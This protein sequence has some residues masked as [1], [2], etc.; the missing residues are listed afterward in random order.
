[1]FD[2]RKGLEQT[3]T[4]LMELRIQVRRDYVDQDKKLS[5]DI[6][7]TLARIRELDSRDGI[8]TDERS[9]RE[10]AATSIPDTPTDQQSNYKKNRRSYDFEEIA[11]KV[12]TILTENSGEM[13][14][15][16]ICRVLEIRHGI[17]FSNRT[18]AFRS[19]IHYSTKIKKE[20][21]KYK[22]V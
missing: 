3:L 14:A 19:M 7:E 21:H 11:K 4:H 8:A 15:A 20:G 6:K 17:S 10:I 18:L 16:Q 5:L 1:M 2:E 13:T 12:E 22:C 9:Y